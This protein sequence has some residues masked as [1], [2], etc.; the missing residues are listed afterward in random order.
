MTQTTADG[1][2]R[3]F[4]VVVPAADLESRLTDRLGRLK[5]QVR[6]NGFRPGKVPVAH[7][8]KLYGRAVMAETIEELV[9]ETNAKIV[10]DN[11]FKLAMEPEIK[12]PEDKDEL[13]RVVSGAADLSYTI[14]LEVV[15]PIELA[16]FKTIT[17]DRPVAEVSR[18]EI[19]D[20][21]KRLA[22]QNK[23]FAARPEG[24]QAENG[25]RLV[26]N[27]TGTLDGVPFEG[28][29]GEDVP[30]VLG[31]GSFI[32]GFEEQL[33]GAKADET[34]TVTVTF[35]ADY[36]AENL[37]GKTAVFE[38]IVKAVEAPEEVTID[39]EFAK[40]L[41]LES[42]EKLEAAITERLKGEHGE[43]SRYKV[44]RALLDKLD[45]LH[46]FDPPP[47]LV[48]EEFKSVWETVT[49]D[50]K[51]QNRSFEDEGTSEEK[52]KEEYRTIADRRV[53]LGLVL[54]EIGEK[55]SIT[56]TDEEVSR[57]IVERARM[58]PGQ[59]QQVWE[60]Y[61]KTPAAV[62]SVRAPIF[63]EKVVDFL[64][65]LATVNDTPVSR[66][67]LFKAEDEG[68]AAAA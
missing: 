5:D 1:L 20:T 12:M 2:K 22:D 47:T 48:E 35:P 16:D 32:P 62:A 43:Q 37:A 46:K 51:R 44:K 65:E 3:E 55:N 14:A 63:E 54:A 15:P 58:Y 11:G 57:A 56:V 7:L 40:R 53:R 34:R 59:E 64:L 27:F 38:V 67:E 41:G 18:E 28:G 60:F 42:L 17:L 39:D 8:R 24:A 21:L 66:D 25:D 30:L 19:D 31:S 4:R 45:E 33:V 61:R 23:A 36:M 6:L 29:S 68:P 13:E 49:S 9:R 26:V 52:A 50:L 10:S